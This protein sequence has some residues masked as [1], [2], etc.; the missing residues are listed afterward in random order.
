MTTTTNEATFAGNTLLEL[1]N[2]LDDLLEMVNSARGSLKEVLTMSIERIAAEI[3]SRSTPL[4]LV[5]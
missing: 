5:A 1:E 2:T 4:L 3:Y